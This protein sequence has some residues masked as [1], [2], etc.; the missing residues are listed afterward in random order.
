MYS[1]IQLG[2]SDYFPVQVAAQAWKR[3]FTDSPRSRYR[4][5]LFW[6]CKSSTRVN[7]S[8][9]AVFLS[10][11]GK[12]LV[13]AY[14]VWVFASVLPRRLSSRLDN[15]AVLSVRSSCLPWRKVELFHRV[16]LVLPRSFEYWT[17]HQVACTWSPVGF[18]VLN[19]I[20]LNGE[21]SSLTVRY[22]RVC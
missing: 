1:P 2:F 11:S 7:A 5:S 21:E 10:L 4:S 20:Q 13:A 3:S 8:G 16:G 15:W 22:G 6:A 12:V 18:R 17:L 9:A 14:F 19:H